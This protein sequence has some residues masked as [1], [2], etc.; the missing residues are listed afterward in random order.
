MDFDFSE[1]PIMNV[2]ISGDFSMRELKEYAETMQDEF[3]SFR[4]I[5]EANIR[6]IEEREIQINVD[7][8]KLDASG[9][10]FN[11]IALAIQLENITMGAGEFT[12]DQTRRVI[13]TRSRL[14]KYRSNCQHHH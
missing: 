2:N 7:P 1:F 3:E 14:Q 5:S 12:A 10:T 4:E 6:G 13:R 9:L 8:Y 11:D